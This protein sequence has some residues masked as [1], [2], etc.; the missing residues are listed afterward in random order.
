M[1]RVIWTAALAALL[2]L[3]SCGRA[4][5]A[6]AGDGRRNDPPATV[7]AGGPGCIAEPM[8]TPPPGCPAARRECV[9][10]GAYSD[11]RWMWVGCPSAY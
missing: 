3:P 11:C 5:R 2:I 10:E 7:S 9:C 8:R 6:A 4:L 1:R